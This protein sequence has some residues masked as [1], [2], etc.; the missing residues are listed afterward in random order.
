MSNPSTDL[1][2][3]PDDTGAIVVAGEI[4]IRTC[5][6][7][8]QVIGPVADQGGVVVLDLAGLEFC[9]STGVAKFVRLHRRAAA[10]G[11]RIV[12]QAPTARF[13]RVLAMTGVDQ[14]FEIR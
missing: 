13:R 4:D 5:D 14:L 6:Q 8:D 2:I 1:T 7:L 12:L 11:G 9:D 10:A 3:R